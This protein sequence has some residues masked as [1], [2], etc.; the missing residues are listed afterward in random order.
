[1]FT[2]FCPACWFILPENMKTCSQCGADLGEYNQLSIEEKYLL[3]LRHPVSENRIIAAQFLGKLGSRKS[4]PEFGRMLRDE[5][6]Y[7]VLREVVRAL[8]L[9]PDPIAR[10]LLTMA[11]NHSYRL[12]SNL[13]KH[14]LVCQNG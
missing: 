13:A 9:F 5:Q 4:L 12:I 14:Y 10:E 11:S 8:T 7:Y 3:A 1:M 6:E 2:Y